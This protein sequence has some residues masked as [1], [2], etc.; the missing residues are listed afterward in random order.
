MTQDWVWIFV[1][2]GD[3]HNGNPELSSHPLYM[4][5]CEICVKLSLS[6]LPSRFILYLCQYNTKDMFKG[7]S[8][9]ILF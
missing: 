4:C 2:Q 9:P 7:G 5:V 3:W 1:E 6:R 8:I